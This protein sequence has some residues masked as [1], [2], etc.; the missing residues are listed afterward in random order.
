[1]THIN[2]RP[3]N[4]IKFTTTVEDPETGEDYEA[5]VVL[6]VEDEAIYFAG[7]HIHLHEL[8]AHIALMQAVKAELDPTERAVT[9]FRQ[10]FEGG[11]AE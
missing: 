8:D 6:S 1:M 2:R 11:V 4:D 3:V 9:E 7:F 5:E 10:R